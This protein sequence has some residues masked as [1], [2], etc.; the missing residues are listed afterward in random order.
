MGILKNVKNMA[1]I[2]S[3]LPILKLIELNNRSMKKVSSSQIK[4]NI[5]CL[6]H[7]YLRTYHKAFDCSSYKAFPPEFQALLYRIVCSQEQI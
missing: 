7:M 5:D 3:V 4:E 2:S 1:K 6:V